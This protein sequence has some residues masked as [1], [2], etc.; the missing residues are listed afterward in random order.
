[1]KPIPDGMNMIMPHLVCAGAAEA[2]DFYTKAFGATEIMRVP[3]GGILIHA[4]VK[5]GDSI[6]LLTDEVP[7][8]GALGP[9]T[10]GGTSV[11]MHHFVNDVDAAFDRAVK[12]GATPRMPPQDMFWG[13]RYGLVEDPF[14]HNWSLATHQRDL[15]PEQI[16]A[17]AAQIAGS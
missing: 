10:R 17:A 4:S 2:I 5:I 13:D 16:A 3:C 15:S 1:M 11:T 6:I 14:G 12:A 8:M 9:K 7:A